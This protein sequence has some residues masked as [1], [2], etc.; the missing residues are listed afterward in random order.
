VAQ[1][2]NLRTHPAVALAWAARR[3]TLHGWV[4]DIASGLIEVLDGAAHRFVPLAEQPD[5]HATMGPWDTN[6]R[7]CS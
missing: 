2:T 3:L 1:L 7:A 5:A 4:Y 6:A